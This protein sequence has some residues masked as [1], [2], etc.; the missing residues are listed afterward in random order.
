MRGRM[1][2]RR[3]PPRRLSEDVVKRLD[4]IGETPGEGSP[5]DFRKFLM[6]TSERLEKII[7]ET[8][9]ELEE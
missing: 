9:I 7:R 8:G 4:D 6:A 5:E 1:N 2:S 3:P